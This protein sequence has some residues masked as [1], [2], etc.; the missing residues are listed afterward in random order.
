[1]LQQEDSQASRQ[2]LCKYA[3]RFRLDASPQAGRKE[4]REVRP[5]DAIFLLLF[6][7]FLLNIAHRDMMAGGPPLGRARAAMR[8][9]SKGL[10]RLR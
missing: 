3:P 7:R 10:S 9:E 5:A 1:M 4:E 8:M 2:V 6:S